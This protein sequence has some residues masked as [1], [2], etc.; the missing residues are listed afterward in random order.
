[1]LNLLPHMPRL[2]QPEHAAPQVRPAASAVDTGQRTT[3]LVLVTEQEVLFSTAAAALV[4]PAASHRHRLR[5][6]LAAAVSH[7]HFALPAP[8]LRLEPFYIETARLSREL[9]RL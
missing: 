1:M 5:T 4:P 7:V 8:R 2:R 3:T 6:T 9:E